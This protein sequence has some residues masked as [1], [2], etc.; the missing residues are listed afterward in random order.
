MSWRWR[1]EFPDHALTVSFSPPATREE[2][3]GDYPTA[4]AAEP[5]RP[6]PGRW[7]TATAL[8]PEDEA[9]IRAWLSRIGERDQDTV[10]EVIKACQ[11]DAGAR[12]YFTRR[13]HQTGKQMSLT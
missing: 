6:S 13:A 10:A 7:S 11:R 1:I 12:E 4:T 8:T 9:A 2:V 3:L 5:V